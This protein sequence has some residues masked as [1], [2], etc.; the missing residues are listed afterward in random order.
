MRVA[1][2]RRQGGRTA[3]IGEPARADAPR[4]RLYTDEER[5]RRDGT[6]WTLVQGI[7]APLQ[8]LVFAVSLALVLRYLATG[9]G[10]AAADASVVLKTVALY[11]I[12]VT[13]ALWEKAVFGR[14]LFARAFFW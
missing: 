2:E 3:T 4:L 5:R 14:Y 10:L 7:L 6:R 12:M 9:Q 13:G 8:F 1:G 11:A